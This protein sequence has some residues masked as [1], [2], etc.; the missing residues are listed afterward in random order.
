MKR[1][2]AVIY[3]MLFFVPI[4]ILPGLTHNPRFLKVFLFSLG[5]FV[6]TYLIAR[7]NKFQLSVNLKILI[8]LIFLALFMI[9][10]ILLG[11][12]LEAVYHYSLLFFPWFLIALAPKPAPSEASVM[13]ALITSSLLVSGI[14]ILNFYG[15]S[16]LQLQLSSPF[17]RGAMVSTIGNVNYVSNFLASVLWVLVVALFVA[18]EKVWR[19]LALVGVFSSLLVV[20][21]SQTR[22]VYFGFAVG[23]IL[24]AFWALQSKGMRWF[25]LKKKRSWAGLLVALALAIFFWISPPGVPEEQTPFTRAVDRTTAVAVG[26]EEGTGGWYQRILEWRIALD[27]FKD[28]PIVGTGFGAYKLL[29]TDYM[30]PITNSDPDYYGYFEKPYEAHSDYLE[31]LAETGIIGTLLWVGMLIYLVIAGVRRVL[32]SSRP[33]ELAMLCGVLTIMVHAIT[34]FPF[35]MMPSLAVFA[36]FG[37][38]LMQDMPKKKLS[39]WFATVLILSMV[40]LLYVQFRWVLGNAQYAQSRIQHEISISLHEEYRMNYNTLQRLEESGLTLD[41]SDIQKSWEFSVDFESVHDK[42]QEQTLQAYRNYFFSSSQ[43]LWSEMINSKSRQLSLALGA[44]ISHPTDY[45]IV[46]TLATTVRQLDEFALEIPLSRMDLPV[47]QPSRL[48]TTIRAMPHQIPSKPGHIADLDIGSR[49]ALES[50]YLGFQARIL[51]LKA[52]M[53][54][55]GYLF[56][57]KT[58]FEIIQKLEE[59]NILDRMPLDQKALWWEWIEYGYKRAILLKGADEKGYQASWNQVDLEYLQALHTYNR[60]EQHHLL[61]SLTHRKRLA[62]YTLS[63]N[64]VF[65]SRYYQFMITLMDHTEFG[66]DPEVCKAFS[67]TFTAYQ[68]FYIE[69]QDYLS[70]ERAKALDFRSTIRLET[71]EYTLFSLE[72][73]EVFLQDFG[74]R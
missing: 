39:S 12:P 50:L 45:F 43:R 71:R 64:W 72:L 62:Q 10:L 41:L 57:G 14:A 34:E 38:I 48:T 5:V 1:G 66:N 69:N 52:P 25:W 53:D 24:F 15:I 20:L 19:I 18:K 23:A 17:N 58:A 28:S 63:K 59:G 55:Y 27:M 56:I 35:H 67:D 21:W 2:N 46:H 29:S 6:I 68:T 22:S 44:T 26:F 32:K 65:P 13:K 40:G 54:P 60:L 16:P 37:M 49:V 4:I 9:Q 30:I 70:Q 47:F 33:I 8:P 51:A 31:M 3:W 7:R 42:L 61:E 11:N 74:S 73:I 36:A